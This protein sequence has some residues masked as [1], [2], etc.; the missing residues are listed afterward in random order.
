M[1]RDSSSPA[2]SGWT[3]SGPVMLTGYAGG[4]VR[5][6]FSFDTVDATSNG[7]EGW[8]VDDFRIMA[9]DYK[10]DQPDLYNHH[11]EL[12]V[13]GESF[14]RGDQLYLSAVVKRG[15][16]SPYAVCDA[17]LAVVLPNGRELFLTPNRA[18]SEEALPVVSN[19]E[20]RDVRVVMGPFIIPSDL[21]GGSYAVRGVLTPARKRAVRGTS[22]VSN[23]SQVSFT[24]NP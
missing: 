18:L 3:G 4:S 16:L 6:R 19:F 2:V 10:V 7:Y 22:V 23:L 15:W 14:R 20:V 24:I 1:A 12:A 5:I 21:A 11:V 17:Y 8:Y 13:N 9:E